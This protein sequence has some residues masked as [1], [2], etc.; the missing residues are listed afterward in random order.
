MGDYF[1]PVSLIKSST[2]PKCAVCE[3]DGIDPERPFK[4]CACKVFKR[5]DGTPSDYWESC[6]QL[7]SRFHTTYTHEAFLAKMAKVSCAGSRSAEG[8]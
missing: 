5:E 1:I 7:G 4:L 6:K 3:G 2:N 8:K